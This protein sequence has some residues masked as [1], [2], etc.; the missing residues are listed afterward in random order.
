[1]LRLRPEV[2]LLRLLRLLRSVRQ[3][4]SVLCL[5]RFLHREALQVQSVP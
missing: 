1:L 3:V 4:R 2:R 5:I